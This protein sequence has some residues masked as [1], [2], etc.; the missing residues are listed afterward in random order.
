MGDN[1]KPT[2]GAQLFGLILIISASCLSAMSGL[3]KGIKWL[4]N[5]NMGL[6]VFLIAFFVLF[7]ATFF[8]LQTFFYAIW[9]YLVALPAMSSTVWT[10]SGD[11]TSAALQSWQGTWTISIG[12]GG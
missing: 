9:D 2:L 8:A 1:G 4:S 12:L 11:A 5:I 7:G 3:K 10:D 6:S